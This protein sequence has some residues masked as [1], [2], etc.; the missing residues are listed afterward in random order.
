ML[1]R[2]F[3]V[4]PVDVDEVSK[5][6]E[7]IEAE[8]SGTEVDGEAEEMDGEADEETNEETDEETNETN[9]EANET[10][11]EKEDLQTDKPEVQVI[12]TP[13]VSSLIDSQCRHSSLS[14]LTYRFAMRR[15]S[16][17]RTS[18]PSSTRFPATRRTLPLFEETS[19]EKIVKTL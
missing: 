4:D 16:S 8:M 12:D 11:E 19:K 14:S 17:P 3:L 1:L 5:E 15:A 18:S 10:N 13:E 2:A 9:E 6:M 7:A